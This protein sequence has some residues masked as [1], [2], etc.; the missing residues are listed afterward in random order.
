M[1]NETRTQATAR[2]DVP[3]ELVTT[4]EVPEADVNDA[5]DRVLA[6]AERVRDPVLLVR[7]KIAV[8][9]DTRRKQPATVTAT[10][11]ANGRIVRAHAAAAG[12]REATDAMVQRLGQQLEDLSRRD[13]AL[14][15]RVRPPAEGEWRRGDLPSTRPEYFD[16]PVDERELVRRKSF[17]AGELTPDEAAFDMERLDHDFHLFREVTADD[18]AVIVRTDDG[19]ALRHVHGEGGEE[20]LVDTAYPTRLDTTPVPTLDVDDALRL[21]DKSGDRFVFFADRKDRGAVVYRRYDGHYGLI[22]LEDR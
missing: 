3:V 21:L 14:R 17:V 2:G 16:R 19:Y 1:A 5:R 6:L 13:E 9:E 7:L 11:D 18:D 4:D 20:Q 15:R 8:A 10:I 22:E 12:V